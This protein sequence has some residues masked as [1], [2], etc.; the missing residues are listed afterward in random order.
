M[1]LRNLTHPDLRTIYLYPYYLQS[2]SSCS[3]T[4]QHIHP[5]SLSKNF[6]N[7]LNFLVL[8]A[9]NNPDLMSLFSPCHLSTA[10]RMNGIIL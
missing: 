1:I 4:S 10:E 6:L 7:S 9:L 5:I 2:S 8:G 3:W